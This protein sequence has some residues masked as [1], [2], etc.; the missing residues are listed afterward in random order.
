MAQRQHLHRG[1]DLQSGGARGDRGGDGQRRTQHGA[2]RLLVDLGQ[3]DRVEP[4]A[5]G[6]DDLL[7]CLRER[8]GVGLL[9]HLAVELMVPAELHGPSVAFGAG[10]R[11]A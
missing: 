8:I 2:R 5:F 11:N 7:E 3:P 6:I 10:Q 1:A 4:P 9:I